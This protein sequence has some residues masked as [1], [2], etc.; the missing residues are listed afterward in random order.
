MARQ[1]I[2]MADRP[3]AMITS[4]DLIACGIIQG[5][6]ENGFNI[7][8]DISV[9]GFDNS[10]PSIV[11]TPKLTTVNQFMRKKAESAV[12]MLLHAM[13]DAAYRNDLK[14]MDVDLVKRSSV[15]RL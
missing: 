1:L 4:E 9:V 12:E 15:A 8:E 13:E 10:V 7:P 2:Q 11:V 5:Y 3:T 14:V 6:Q